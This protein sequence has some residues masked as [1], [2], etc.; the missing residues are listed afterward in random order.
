MHAAAQAARSA[1]KS[2]EP[3]P[4][5][6][7]C[8]CQDVVPRHCW[9]QQLPGD[10]AE[11][12]PRRD[13]HGA[14]HSTAQRGRSTREQVPNGFD[15]D[16]HATASVRYALGA[17]RQYVH[18][19]KPTHTDSCGA[20]L[21]NGAQRSTACACKPCWQHTRCHRQLAGGTGVVQPPSLPGHGRAQG[22]GIPMRGEATNTLAVKGGQASAWVP[23]CPIG[24]SRGPCMHHSCYPR[25]GRSML[26]APS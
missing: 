11:R 3:A 20:V 5:T 21:N 4:S 2:L 24:R 23:W 15:H 7:A 6:A 12:A 9:Q 10:L 19:L 14:L 26:Q 18:S 16:P 1:G 13:V 8:L 17:A 22:A 25:C